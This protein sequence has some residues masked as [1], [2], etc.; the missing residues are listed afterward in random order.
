MNEC[1]SASK[2]AA[3]FIGQLAEI[4]VVAECTTAGEAILAAQCLEPHILLLDSSAPSRELPILQEIAKLGS[5]TKVAVLTSSERKSD[6]LTAL[7]CGASGYILRSSGVSLEAALLNIH[8]LDVYVSPELGARVLFD[9]VQSREITID[10]ESNW[11]IAEGGRLTE[12]EREVIALVRQGC[13]NKE[14]A[15]RLGIEEATVKH[16]LRNIFRKLRIRSRVE[17]AALI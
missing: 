2:S 5:R 6:V 10:P 13:R 12:R 4:A 16:H 1:A 11:L 7:R 8:R 14:I 15:I 17:L 3:D 9:L